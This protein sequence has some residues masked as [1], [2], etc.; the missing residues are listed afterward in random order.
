MVVNLLDAD[1]PLLHEMVKH[2][3]HE[4]TKKNGGM[5]DFQGIS[6]NHHHYVMCRLSM[7]I[8]VYTYIYIYIS[9]MDPQWG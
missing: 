4:P 5:E 3:N 9:P 8:Y 2:V 6:F 1:K 7:Y